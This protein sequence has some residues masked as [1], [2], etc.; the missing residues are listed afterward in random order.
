MPLL[1]FRLINT[2]VSFLHYSSFIDFRFA[3]FLRYFVGIVLLNACKCV[4][5]SLSCTKVVSKFSRSDLIC[6]PVS[7]QQ[8]DW[9]EAEVSWH[10]CICLQAYVCKVYMR[11]WAE[12]VRGVLFLKIIYF[13]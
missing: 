4:R 13:I 11:W 5:R 9:G 7:F 2:C 8:I 12:R 10:N 6:D 1:A 3:F